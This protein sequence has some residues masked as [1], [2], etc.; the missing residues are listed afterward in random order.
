MEQNNQASLELI[1]SQFHRKLRSFIYSKVNDEAL[2]D[3]LLQDVFIKVHAQIGSLKD[4]TKIQ[5]WL[6]RIARNT[7]YDHFRRPSKK[8]DLDV[9]DLKVIDEKEDR[10]LINELLNDMAV[11]MDE[12]PPD[13]CDVLCRTELEGMSHKEYAD[14]V[15]I[16]VTAAKTRAFR[17]RNM[18]KDM[19]MKCCHY[20]FDKY[21]TVLDIQP[22][23][24]CCCSGHK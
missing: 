21:G 23:G 10:S 12:M 13:Y 14:R 22:A 7:V 9:D 16:S 2:A 19:L 17:A 18:L 15:G 4:E 11:T 20:Q 8:S 6:Y 24:C 5:A 3:D 1:W